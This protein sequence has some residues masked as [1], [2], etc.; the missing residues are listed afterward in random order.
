M[1]GRLLPQAIRS[2]F[3]LA[4]ERSGTA[5]AGLVEHLKAR[6]LLLLLDNCEHLLDACAELSLNLLAGCPELTVLTTSRAPLDVPGELAWLVPSL[7]IPAD[8]AGPKGEWLGRYSALRLFAERAAAARPGF[9][10][11]DDNVTAV[12]QIC[13][14]LDGIPLAIELAA[15]RTRV[16]GVE[17]IAARLDDC[18]RLF[19]PGGRSSVPRQVTLRSSIDW[20]YEL[21]SDQ[22]QALFQHLAVFA[23]GWTLEAAEAICPEPSGGTQ[24]LELL[25]QLVEKSLVIV[26]EKMATRVMASSRPSDSMRTK[27]CARRASC[28]R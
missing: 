12:A 1:T 16:L 17:Q 7:T 24:V 21:L 26:E 11:N 27:S 28:Q 6:R 22:E 9:G 20:S 23:G 15:V 3:G 19:G 25:A 10:L 14:R 13:R 2:V 18:F 4:E 8:A 5:A